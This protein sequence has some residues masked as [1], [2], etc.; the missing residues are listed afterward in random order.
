MFK[1]EIN[2]RVFAVT[3]SEL[4]AIRAKGLKVSFVL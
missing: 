1:V 2:N 3:G 4:S